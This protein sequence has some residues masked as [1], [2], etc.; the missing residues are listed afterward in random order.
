MHF[1]AP[2]LLLGLAAAVLPALIH[3]IGRRRARPIR[4]AAMELL[5]RADR[6]VAA[7][8]KLRDRLLLFARTAL[9]AALPLVFARPFALVRSDLP[10]VTGRSQSAVVVLD[11]SASMRRRSSAG[12]PFAVARDRARA[13]IEHLSPDSEV[14]IVLASQGTAS[15]IAELSGDRPR[16]LAALESLTCS[17]RAADF[18]A[19]LRRAAQILSSS[20]RADRLIYVATDLQSAGWGDVTPA[21]LA[22]VP[23]VVVMDASD[24]AAWTNRAVLDVHAEPAPEEGAQGLAVIAE[25]A[26]FSPE[27]ARGLGVTLS[28]DGAETARGF[29][30]VPAGGRARKRF[31]LTASGGHEAEVA[32]DHDDFPLDDRRAS[33]VEAARGLR[34]LVVDGDPRTVRTEDET[35]FLEAALRAGGSGFSVATVL[36]DQLGDRDLSDYGAIFI[37]NVSRP[38]PAAAE[39]LDRYVRRG[40]GL[41]VSVG[42][43]VDADAWNQTMR[44]LL[45]Q[46]LGLARSAAA[47]PGAHPEGE[48]VDLRPAERLAPFDRRHPLLSGFPARG[49]GLSSAR[50]FEYMLLAPVPDAPARRILLRYESGAPALVET[51]VGRGR[52]LLLTTSID[53]EWTDLPIRAGFLP[54]VQEAARYLAGAPSGDATAAVAVGD[55]REIALEPDERRI[56]VVRPAGDSRWLLPAARGDAHTRRTVVFTETDEPGFYRVRAARADGSI[57]DRADASFVVDVDPGESDP[58]RLPED[59][60]PDR[61]GGRPG[62]GAAPQRRLELWHWLGA[63]A[64]ALVLLESILTLRFRRNRI[65]A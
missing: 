20:T 43:H 23:A 55:K 34:I 46:P 1:L 64:I 65:R 21:A 16:V 36:P 60:R 22:G 17:A 6:E 28:I 62:A 58:A 41:F 30:D 48:T 40:G 45:P 2:S 33:L 3:R 24:G 49:E 37:A 59:R 8:R 47:L 25:I 61:A 31:V 29:V 26:N 57:A 38:S 14:A 39:A 63:A 52:V 27:P 18:G 56:E 54:L 53:R 44:A 50:F 32:I 5:L 15:P 42:D 11:D 35:F 19:A 10:A 12:T 4:F 7:R 9:A 51:Q 13:V